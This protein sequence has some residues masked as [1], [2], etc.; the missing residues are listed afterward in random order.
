EIKTIPIDP[1]AIQNKARVIAEVNPDILLLQE[2]EDRS[3]LSQFNNEYLP[4]FN[5]IPYRELLVLQ[6]NDEKGQEI[7]LMTK[8]GYHINMVKTFS[9]EYDQ[10]D[11]LL[12]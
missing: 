9:N 1:V 12:F 5:A 3:S 4:F 2:V 10:N 6:G 11:N 7:G 8:N